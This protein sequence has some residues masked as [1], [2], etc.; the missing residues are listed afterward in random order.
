MTLANTTSIDYSIL[1]GEISVSMDLTKIV[2][3]DVDACGAL[4][5]TLT[6]DTLNVASL[7]TTDPSNPLVVLA[8]ATSVQSI[9]IT[10]TVKQ[11]GRDDSISHSFTINYID[12]GGR[13]TDVV[14]PVKKY[15]IDLITVVQNILLTMN[16]A[17]SE[18]C[19]SEFATR[20]NVW[21]SGPNTGRAELYDTSWVSRISDSIPGIQL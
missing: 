1:S 20:T 4:N 14:F 11:A 21:V 17:T 2:S 7:D 5:Y 13:Y 16:S 19:S 12:C 9:T 10:V 8:A 3:G 6:A 18:T 15:A